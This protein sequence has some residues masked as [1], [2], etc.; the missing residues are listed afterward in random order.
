MLEHLIKS[1]FLSGEFE[2]KWCRSR[3]C[4]TLIESQGTVLPLLDTWFEANL[5]QNHPDFAT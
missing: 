3:T 1:L 4:D 5:R 2:C